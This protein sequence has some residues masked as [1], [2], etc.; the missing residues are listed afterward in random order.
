MKMWKAMLKGAKM[1]PQLFGRLSDENG[2]SCAAGSILLGLT[3]EISLPY[4]VIL[5]NK[6]VSECILGMPMLKCPKCLK[7]EGTTAGITETFETMWFVMAHLNNDHKWSRQ[8]IAHWVRSIEDPES[9]KKTPK[10]I[11][12]EL[13]AKVTCDV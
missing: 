12:H 11:I 5:V 1:G 3:G 9:F 4:Y 2:G 6:P 13:P 7:T 8:N 10:K